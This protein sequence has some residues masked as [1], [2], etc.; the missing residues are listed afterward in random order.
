MPLS[1]LLVL[2]LAPVPALPAP[3]TPPGL[4]V[5]QDDFDSRRKAAAGDLEL[6]WELVD[7]CE[8][9]GLQKERDRVL[10]DVIK[11]EPDDAKARELL[12][13]VEYDGQWFTT[14][15]KLEAY[16]K[17]KEREERKALEREAKEKGW[18]RY[19]DTW[20]DPNNVPKLEAG[21]VRAEDGTWVSPEELQKIEAG[22][23]RQ[24][25]VWVSPEEASQLDAGLWKCGDEWL[26]L[27]AANRYHS[28]LDRWWRIPDGYFTL[29]TT[30]D[31]EL[32]YKAQDRMQ[33]AYRDLVRLFGVTPVDP[34]NVL[35][36][37]NSDQYRKFTEGAGDPPLPRSLS[38]LSSVHGSFFADFWIDPEVGFVGAGVSY[39]NPDN[40]ADD[41]FGNLW[42]RHAAGLSFVEGIDPSPE[43][44]AALQAGDAQTFAQGFW[45]EKVL[46]NWLRYGAASY[47]ERYY[48]DS[49]VGPDG[50]PL[51]ARKWSVSNIAGR[52]GLDALDTI[53]ELKLT[54][55]DVEG[56]AKRLNEAGLLVAFL[57]DGQSAAMTKEHQK[58]KAA[59]KAWRKNP[60]K[61]ASGVEKAVKG[62]ERAFKKNWKDLQ[63]FAGI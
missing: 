29:W 33:I 11:L 51:W 31:R 20:V 36:V 63:A 9:R 54:P 13:H 21:F 15:K 19:G 34:P 62:L 58:F 37:R 22:W 59:M 25:L 38:G 35:I 1:A 14:A 49:F 16:K 39:W 30:V 43:A 3:T 6:L 42:C 41:R 52:G 12:G 46:P 50:D 2:L 18:V 27:E 48:H 26:E 53:L 57:L 17:K 56:S 32:A 55:D 60:A 28:E 8:A 61:G 10:R 5:L 45:D 4:V 24:D 7:W 23:K 44:L 47:V 40:E